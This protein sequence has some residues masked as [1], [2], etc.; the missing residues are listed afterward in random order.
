MIMLS[1]EA[2]FGCFHYTK[3]QLS[4]C[5][6]SF[7]GSSQQKDSTSGELCEVN[8]AMQTA[9]LSTASSYKN[10]LLS[11][12]VVLSPDLFLSSAS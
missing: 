4:V 6:W 10:Y 12:Q 11:L 9:L 8:V 7:R 2:I 3:E 5:H 1:V